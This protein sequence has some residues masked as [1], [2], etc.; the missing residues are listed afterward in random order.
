MNCMHCGRDECNEGFECTSR[1]ASGRVLEIVNIGVQ[2]LTIVDEERVVERRT[3]YTA[4]IVWR[5]YASLGARVAMTDVPCRACGS[6]VTAEHKR[7]WHCEVE[8]PGT[9][10]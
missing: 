5:Y 6:S 1:R 10:Q 7:C 8:W 4:S 9:A 2:P 3:P